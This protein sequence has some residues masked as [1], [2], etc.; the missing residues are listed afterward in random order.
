MISNEYSFEEQRKRVSAMKFFRRIILSINN[1]KS[2][3]E[4]IDVWER[5]Y[6]EETSMDGLISLKNII[7][8]HSIHS[9][10]SLHRRAE[11][12]K[13]KIDEKISAMSFRH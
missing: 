6:R 11:R 7:E 10:S 9:R 3:K 1:Y 8:R 4:M 13:R 5:N 2:D 12:L